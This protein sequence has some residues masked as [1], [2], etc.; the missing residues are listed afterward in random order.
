LDAEEIQTVRAVLNSERFPDCSPAAI[1]ATLLDEGRYLCST[2]TMYRVLEE[3]G[4]TRE[5]RDQLNV[6]L[7]AMRIEF[8][9]I[10]RRGPV[11]LYGTDVA[12]RKNGQSLEGEKG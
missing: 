9:Y 4:A 1:N 7:A 5:R 11:G 6:S 12:C 3:D 10:A 2:R 8:E